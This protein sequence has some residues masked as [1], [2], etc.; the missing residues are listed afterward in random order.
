[1]ALGTQCR[2][3]HFWSYS[4]LQSPTWWENQLVYLFSRLGADYRFQVMFRNNFA[5]SHDISGLFQSFQSSSSVLDPAANPTLFQSLLMIIIKV[6]PRQNIG[7]FVLKHSPL[8]C[9]GGWQGGHCSRVRWPHWV[10][11][12]LTLFKGSHWNSKNLCKMNKMQI[13]LHDCTMAS[14]LS[15]HGQQLVRSNS[16]HYSQLSGST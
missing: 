7:G 13:S 9:W 3:T 10:L 5:L 1:M 11:Q 16:T 14:L 12:L 4:M 8:G 6:A 2:R 15:S